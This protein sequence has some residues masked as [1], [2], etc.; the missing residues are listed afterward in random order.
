M[1]ILCWDCSHA[2]AGEV[3]SVENSL[4]SD[5]P[6]PPD[7]FVWGAGSIAR[8]RG[9]CRSIIVDLESSLGS[10]ATHSVQYLCAL[11]VLSELH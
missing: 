6:L 9:V 8:L 1:V 11:N 3:Y 10:R 2:L 4:R 7:V 5:A